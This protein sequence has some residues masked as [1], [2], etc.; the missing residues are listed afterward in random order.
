M[1]I[2]VESTVLVR[3]R[4]QAPMDA[5]KTRSPT[6][7]VVINKVETNDEGK[8]TLGLVMTVL[9]FC[10]NCAGFFG[11]ASGSVMIASEGFAEFITTIANG[12][13]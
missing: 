5:V 10:M 6:E 13:M 7:I 8:R 4:T 2:T 3:T 12:I 11:S 9:T 1:N